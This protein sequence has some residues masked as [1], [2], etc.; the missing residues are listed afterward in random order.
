MREMKR[1]GMLVEE[2]ILCY[3]CVFVGVKCRRIFASLL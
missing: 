3:V 1:M 2:P